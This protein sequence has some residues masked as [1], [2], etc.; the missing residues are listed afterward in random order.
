MLLGLLLSSGA[1]CQVPALLADR[2]EAAAAAPASPQVVAIAEIPARLAADLRSVQAIHERSQGFELSGRPG[3]ELGGLRKNA[4]DLA[5]EATTAALRRLPLSGLEA[6]E[7]HLSFLERELNAWLKD[8]QR[9]VKPLAEDAARL[10][11]LRERWTRTREDSG[12]LLVPALRD[13]IGTL[14]GQIA[15]A[16]RGVSEAMGSALKLTH[17][18]DALQAQVER[19][20]ADVRAGIAVI[21][22]GLLRIDSEP[23]FTAL[24][25]AHAESGTAQKALQASL[26][27]EAEFAREYDRVSRPRI[28]GVLLL[29]VLLLPLCLWLSRQ[30]RQALADDDRLERYRKTLTRPFSAWLLVT[31]S[32]LVLLQLDGPVLRERFLLVLAWLPVMRLQPL[33]RV[34]HIA[35]WVY[36]TAVFFLFNLLAQAL[37]PSPT[38]FR[39][40]LLVNGLLMLV[41]L[42]W[43]IHRNRVEL[44]QQRTRALL[45]IRALAL[46]AL[47]LMVLAVVANGVGNVSLA[48]MLTDATLSSAYLGL[49]LFALAAVLRA[50]ANLLLRPWLDRVRSRAQR[51]DGLLSVASRL[52][53]LALLSAWVFGTLS[54]LRLLRPLG[55]AATALA[56]VGF[57]FGSISLTLGGVALFLV[58][59]FLSFW[60]SKTVRGVLAEDLLPNMALP[61]GVANSISSLSYY[62]LLILGLMVA[63]A[64]AGF[65]IS[66]LAIVLGALSVGI[67]LGL[68]DVVKNFVS[69]LILMVERPLQPGDIAEV[70]GTLGRV[71]DIGMRATTLTTFEG[72]DVIVP[73]GMLLTEK[74]VNWTLNSNKRRIDIPIGVAYGSD[75]REVLA[76]LSA[77]TAGVEGV[78]AEPAPSVLFSGFGASSLDFSVRVWAHVDDAIVA[79]NAMAVALWDALQKAGIEIPFPQQDLHIRSVPAPG[80]PGFPPRES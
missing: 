54:S 10:A 68:Q 43:L 27:A 50:F 66:Q 55:E 48:A 49:F 38:L 26:H 45:A 73:N 29:S 20:L 25:S 33:Q 5:Q 76:L 41:A 46:L 78:A 18:A 56:A 42:A 24:G 13:G 16:E 74:M 79:R 63:L 14:L 6:L 32:C 1:P 9:Q 59:V 65:Q 31:L 11:S 69:G 75:P 67:G 37:S 3:A 17:E 7:R 72:A 64:A 2:A 22:R 40:A 71:R 15:A 70:S 21:D 8:V 60:L 57:G 12:P 19:H 36:L 39:L 28:M 53:N 23:L 4:E 61:R 77:A 47:C 80:V 58:S 52:F 34:D 51:A 44:T 30:A 35:R 62:T